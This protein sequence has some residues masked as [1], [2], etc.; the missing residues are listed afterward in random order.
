MLPLFRN[1]I[2]GPKLGVANKAKNY[3]NN[4]ANCYLQGS[5]SSR[6]TRARLKGREGTRRKSKPVQKLS[7]G[8]KSQN[9]I[10]TLAHR[11]HTMVCV[12]VCVPGCPKRPIR[13][14]TFGAFAIV[15][16]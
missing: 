5:L 2:S 6:L 16:G 8:R 3:A 13:P 7:F 9:N 1:T 10:N 11:R 14:S 15:A 12:C 4:L